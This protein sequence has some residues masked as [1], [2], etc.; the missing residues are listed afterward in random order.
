MQVLVLDLGSVVSVANRKQN[1]SAILEAS[2]GELLDLGLRNPLINYR[3]SRAKG[4]EVVDELP[5]EVFRILVRERKAMTFKEAPEGEG[6]NAAEGE[7][8][9][10]QPDH[11]E[12]RTAARHVDLRL[13]T[14]LS[15]SKL[16]SRLIKTE[17]EART[18]VEEQ[19][20][21]V[22]FLALGM[23][24]WY[25]AESSRE[26]RQ[27]PLILVPVALERANVREK[28]RLLYTEEDLEENLSLASKLKLEFG[29][30]FPGMPAQEDL[31]VGCYF[32]AVEESVGGLPRWSVDRDAVALGFF[33][34]GKLLMYRD[35]DEEN[36][37]KGGA[38]S[39][40]PIIRTLFDENPDGSEPPQLAE[41]EHLDEH[42]NPADVHHVVDADSTQSLALLDAKS[43]RS[44]VIQGPP[45]TGKS[46][47]I[48]NLIA[49]A[50]GRG[51][52]VLFVAEKMAALEVVKR[53][54]DRV[55]LGDACLE[56]HSRKT[57]KRAVLQ[58]LDRT[59][60]LGRPKLEQVEDDLKILTGLRD[61]LN[62]YSEAMNA[63]IGESGVTPYRAIGELVRLG[64]EAASLPRV[65]FDAMRGWTGTDFRSRQGLVE[66]LQ[67][68]L[69][70]SGVPNQNPFYGSTRSVLLPTEE[71]RIGHSLLTARDATRALR[72]SAAELA[73]TL[74]LS[75]PETREEA[76]VLCRAARR[77]TQAPRLEG[78]RLA[79]GEWQARRDD[80]RTLI[81]AGKGYAAVRGRYE[82]LLIPEAWEQ[83]LLETRQHLANYGDRW[84]GFLSGE[85]REA[86]NRLGGLSRGEL[87]RDNDEQLALVDAVL[88]AQHHRKAIADHETL[89]ENLFGAQWQ[90]ERSDWPVLDK[91][92]EWIVQLYREVGEERL[93]EGLIDFLSGDPRK[94]GLEERIAATEGALVD[95]A[96]AVDAAAELLE[97]EEGALS[98]LGAQALTAQ[99]SVFD[100]WH[101]GLHRLR[102]LVAYNQL[103]E[104]C[105]KEGLEGVLSQAESWPE[106]GT[107][108]VD[109]YRYTWFEG[110]VE[111]AFRERPALARFDRANHEYVA[112]KF[113][114]LDKLVIEHNRA[115]L[116]H[117]HWRGVP[118]HE[119][120]GQLGVL[121]REIQKKR[122]HLPIRHLVRR[123]GDAIQ[124]IKPVLMMGPLS[125]ANYLEPGAL[126]FDLVV[127][128][129]ASQ[130]RPV[131]ALGAIARG[132]QVVVV[133]DGKQLP[134]TSF[135][136]RMVAAEEAEEESLTADLES[137]L[138]L[139]SAQGVPE[140]MLRWHYRSRHESLITV[141]NHEFYEDRLV[142]FPSPDKGR[143]D[144]GLVYHHLPDTVYDR[145]GTRS[146][147]GEAKR[148]AQA[149]MEHARERPHLTLGV[150]AFSTAQMQA[151]E[152]QLEILR[153]KDPSREGFFAS[154]PHEPFF[155]KNLE[156]VQGDERDVVF[157]SVGYGRIAGGYV[158]MS[159]GPLNLDGG[160]RRL[161]V[162]ITRARRVCEVFTNLTADDI[163]LNR[164]NARG[165]RALKTFLQYAKS[166]QLDV[167]VA[168]GREPDSP[169]E[170]AVLSALLE[171]GYRVETQVGSAGFF[172][173]L[174]VVDPERP[175]RYLL[176]VECDGAT[177]HSA[178]SARDR[179]RLRQEVLEG[180]GWRIHRIWSTDWFR[181]PEGELRRAV[182]A[183]EEAKFYGGPLRENGKGLG[184]GGTDIPRDEGSDSAT[185]PSVPKYKRA[186][187]QLS[188]YGE[189]HQAS[190][191]SLGDVVADIVGVES[192]I[193]VQ[194]LSRRVTEAA[195]ITR[196]GSRIRGVIEAALRSAVR[197]RKVRRTGD[198]LWH[199][200]MQES[201]LR[202]RSG[203][204]D[205][206]KKLEF[207]APEEV[208]AAIA[209]VVADSYGMGRE[210]IPAAVLRLLFG[211]KRTT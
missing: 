81:A 75:P 28:F 193:H 5:A 149:V 175:G 61:R 136:D 14:R 65:G 106:A 207:V 60:R 95:Q 46:Q 121:R 55:G 108:L 96:A 188:F 195:D 98:S 50:I 20:V 45:G 128:D 53:R 150:A 171:A 112:E 120:G 143:E 31:D 122:R 44:L 29:A 138:G 6:G 43:G 197:H 162:L 129:E 153:R 97:L 206:S 133:G 173:D 87:P 165:V 209:K 177:Y 157:I 64:P 67:A 161:N 199:P 7:W 4:V 170:E 88:E 137:V 202:D 10:D 16:Q 180:L 194:E 33:S 30:E 15:S 186:N 167:P 131:E 89:G 132:K 17:R 83:D 72:E 74:A 54:L 110:L 160:E 93:P 34:F 40:H 168:T 145:G 174:A 113:C 48:T 203:L 52:T 57:N 134:P 1:V 198:F 8:V 190:P 107:R 62:G 135:F 189:F 118:T 105:R 92:V 151:I 183:I 76:E 152:D 102:A 82:D 38:P 47:T 116:A 146:N 192:P 51:R 141:S 19:G 201:P 90:G 211:F 49:E 73:A 119:A 156:N 42:I 208:E 27:A 9:L 123:A 23:L 205:A 41:D 39:D 126:D 84:W 59:M 63:P 187:V 178:R 11:S 36:W 85:Y 101:R 204:P 142:V 86:R 24:R 25:E 163:D 78:V 111:E 99:E 32:D 155:V 124:A 37:P 147:V 94:A 26:H 21:N 144:V 3:P 179:D 71:A 79:S 172:I 2:R 35:L 200:D 13:Q 22:L 140:R 70:Q 69:S 117:A 80:L 158:P 154:H 100:S 164:S 148:V 114:E 166:G 12:G 159:F 91:L 66:E 115:R 196:T 125:I 77:A 184:G 103:S 182:E 169:F 185:V 176:G 56:L 127:F 139:F 104:T 58:E 18:F 181:N 210:E 130:V 191:D 68:N 109:A